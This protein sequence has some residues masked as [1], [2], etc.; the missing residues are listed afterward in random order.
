MTTQEIQ[1][2]WTWPSTCKLDENPVCI[3]H[4][5]FIRQIIPNDKSSIYD[6]G[7]LGKL[8]PLQGDSLAWDV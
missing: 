7:P 5:Q 2:K 1:M 6:I 8:K 4:Q 3:Q